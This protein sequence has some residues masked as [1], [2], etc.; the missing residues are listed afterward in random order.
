MRKLLVFA[1]IPLTVLVIACSAG[2]K[3][4]STSA[5]GDGG[6]KAATTAAEPTTVKAGQPLTLTQS[7]LGSDTVATI[8]VSNVKYGVQ[9]KNEFEKPG[10][11]QYIT[12]DVTVSV[13]KGKFSISSG[14]FKLVAKDGT[15]YDTTFLSDV[16]DLS[17]NDLTHGQKTSGTIVFD[18]AKGAQ[19]GGKIALKDVLADGDAGYWT[20]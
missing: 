10:K 15:A 14:S 19:T 18:A 7:I 8:T 5:P 12:A 16:Q 2:T 3:S 4:G 13:S 1:A 11:G 17:G 6:A 20:L 9:S